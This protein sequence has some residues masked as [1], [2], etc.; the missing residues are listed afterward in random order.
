MIQ[1]LLSEEEIKNPI[2]QKANFKANKDVSDV[3][4]ETEQNS[5]TF[6]RNYPN[7]PDYKQ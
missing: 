1:S 3:F 5:L 7:L 4:K 6:N 2:L